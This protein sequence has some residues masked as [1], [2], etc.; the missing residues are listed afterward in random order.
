MKEIYELALESKNPESLGI[1][2][3]EIFSEREKKEGYL[4]FKYDHGIAGIKFRKEEGKFLR[5]IEK[6]RKGFAIASFLFFTFF[7]FSIPFLL[8]PSKKP[9]KP[10]KVKEEFFFTLGEMLSKLKMREEELT[11]GREEERRKAEELRIISHVIFNSLPFPLLLLSPDKRI[12]NIN[13][14]GEEFFGRSIFSLIYSPVSSVLSSDFLKIIEDA[15]KKGVSMEGTIKKND[16]W[17]LVQVTP[18]KGDK[19]DI[20]TILML[21]DITDRK[22]EEEILK[23]KEKWASLGEMASYLAHEIKNSV[24]ISLGYLKMASEKE[25]YFEKV[26][27]ELKTVNSNIEKFLDFARPLVVRKETVELREVIS[28][29]IEGFKGMEVTFEGKFPPFRADK[30]LLKIVFFNLIKNSI[31]ANSS[32]VEIKSHW[33]EGDKDILIDFIDNGDGI[34]QEKIEKVFLPFFSTKEGGAGLG[35]PLC[36]KIILHHGGDIK[37]IPMEKGTGIRISLPIE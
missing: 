36:K 34:P 37:V 1:E 20:G 2:D 24:G 21:Q 4:L 13:R 10:P 17:F 16:R 12:L 14:G 27:K 25:T 8:I 30:S 18:V 9:L 29:I 31:E 26:I 3:L 23:E 19:G 15:E 33:K 35:L 5:R 6:I 7:I 28:E 11:R 32:M 22:R